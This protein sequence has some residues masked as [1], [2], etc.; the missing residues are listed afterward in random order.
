MGWLIPVIPAL[1]KVRQEN[2]EFE[3]RLGHIASLQKKRKNK[4]TK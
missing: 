3:A 1:R 4:Q 2:C